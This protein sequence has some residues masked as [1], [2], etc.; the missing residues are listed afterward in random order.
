MNR[1]VRVDFV[2][3]TRG[4]PVARSRRLRAVGRLRRRLNVS[5][6]VP[7]RRA[8]SFETLPRTRKLAPARTERRALRLL[9]PNDF[10]GLAAAASAAARAS[11]AGARGGLAA[12]EAGQQ[13]GAALLRR[14]MAL[15]V[16]DVEVAGRARC[17]AR[18]SREA[19]SPWL[20][21]PSARETG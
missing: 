19:T 13:G 16:A 15:R 5:R 17:A 20:P 9:T 10:A 11:A 18:K 1:R 2:N 14:A 3:R 7:V 8:R 6:P 12:V 4:V 21:P